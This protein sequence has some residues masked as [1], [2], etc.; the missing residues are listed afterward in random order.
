MIKIY[1]QNVWNYSPA[2]YRNSLIFS[3]ISDC[4]ADICLFQ[5]CGPD[6]I[7]SAEVCLPSLMEEVYQEVC[8]DLADKNYT[9]VYYKK[10]KFDLLDSGYFL[11]DGLNDANSKSV[12]WALLKEKES[13]EKFVV[14]STHFWWM[15]ESEKDNEQRLKNV[16]QLHEFCES[17][18]A[19]YDVPVIVGGDLNNGKNSSQGEEPYEY[20]KQKG[21]KDIRLTAEKTTDT[22]TH[23][24]Y[25]VLNENGIYE[26][27]ALPVRTIDYIFT[28]GDFNIKA[29]KFDVLTSR[30]ALDSSDHCPLTGEFEI[31]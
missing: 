1:C 7:R 15:Y 25:P 27:G 8:I 17:V 24:A 31:L 22:H 2:S 23:H 5:E 20:M 13:A 30:K 21:F 18:I 28:Y 19:K 16:E 29:K 10:E 9:P 26:N 3:L 14:V 6:T 12:T 4:D 11:Y